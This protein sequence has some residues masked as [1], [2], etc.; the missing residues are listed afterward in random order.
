MAKND[1]ITV[2]LGNL[3]MKRSVKNKLRRAGYTSQ[4]MRSAARLLECLRRRDSS[5]ET[6]SD[7]LIPAKCMFV[8]GTIRA[9]FVS[10][11]YILKVSYSYII[12]KI[13]L[14]CMQATIQRPHSCHHANLSHAAA[15]FGLN[16]PA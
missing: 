4:K 5:C 9:V 13:L 16:R 11:A 1:T 8:T 6:M 2:E 7:F 14:K 3:W 15:S 12:C 10:M